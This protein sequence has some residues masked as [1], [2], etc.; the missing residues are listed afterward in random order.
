MHPR[1]FLFALLAAVALSGCSSLSPDLRGVDFNQARRSGLPKSKDVWL[2]LRIPNREPP[3]R[4]GALL[5]ADPMQY[6]LSGRGAEL[7]VP[8]SDWAPPADQFN[9]CLGRRFPLEIGHCHKMIGD[10]VHDC[11]LWEKKLLDTDKPLEQIE[12]PGP[13]MKAACENPAIKRYN[14]LLT[15]N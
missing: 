3:P 8:A 5:E 9:Y 15:G 4:P 11:R 13:L 6:R 2:P 7:R 1:S 12:R 14:R 10:V